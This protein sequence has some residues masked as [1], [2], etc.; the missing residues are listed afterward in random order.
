LE[1]PHPNSWTSRQRSRA[2]ANQGT[3][4]GVASI[5]RCTQAPNKRMNIPDTVT[6][7]GGTRPC[8]QTRTG[9]APRRPK[10]LNLNKTPTSHPSGRFCRGVAVGQ[11]GLPEPASYASSVA[12][13]RLN[14][15]DRGDRA[16]TPHSMVTIRRLSPPPFG[17]SGR[18]RH[19]RWHGTAGHWHRTLLAPGLRSGG[20][21][22]CVQRSPER[23]SPQHSD[24]SASDQHRPPHRCS[25]RSCALPAAP[26]RPEWLVA[27]SPIVANGGRRHCRART[28][29][30]RGGPTLSSIFCAL[31]TPDRYLTR[32]GD[33]R[34]HSRARP[35]GS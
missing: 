1:H 19:H 17:Y 6:F 8:R 10:S 27:R 16:T 25:P 29:G 33:S 28:P 15:A 34:C 12:W 23:V 22:R 35:K 24:P 4:L 21:R 26:R 7:R 2:T 13:L 32:P 18:L 5:T 30:V 20:L 9:Q 3:Q 31:A 11:D 14:C